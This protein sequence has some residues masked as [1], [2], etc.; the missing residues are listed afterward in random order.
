M[1]GT[2]S[3]V[4]G[5]ELQDGEHPSHKE[6]TTDVK[7]I[8]PKFHSM[9]SVAKTT[10]RRLG[11][12]DIIVSAMGLGVASF[13][14]IYG[15]APS[16]PAEIVRTS[17][18]NGINVID[19]GYWYGQRRSEATLGKAL[20]NIPRHVYYLCIRVGRF[21]LD[22]A[23]PFDYRADKILT[24]LTKSLSLLNQ[25][26]ADICFLQVADTEWENNLNTILEETLPALRIAQNSNKIKY[27]GLAGYS[28]SKMRKIID[29]SSIKIN[30]CLNYCRA[31]LMD[32]SLAESIKYFNEKKIGVLNGGCFSMGMLT[33]QGPPLWHPANYNTR[34]ITKEAVN[35]CKSK[36]IRIEKLSLSYSLR[37]PGITCCLVSIENLSQLVINLTT[38][39]NNG[40]LQN[41]ELRVLDRIKR[42]Y[43]DKIEN[44]EWDII[45]LK[46]YWRHLETLGLPFMSSNRISSME[47]LSSN[48][49]ASI[50]SAC[51]KCDP[52][53]YQK[54][55]RKY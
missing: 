46:G 47:S 25:K 9:D 28:L 3:H 53:K 23:R 37:F 52:Y 18:V 24:S 26:Y 19:T 40:T 21:E 41:K 31:T 12:T 27:I 33:E 17:L 51:S 44:K 49:T 42:R 1:Q 36:D 6:T 38:L 32:N 48:Y 55:P 16:D 43:L 15:P 5:V 20:K 50:A 30:V 35:Y 22:Y 34:E 14:E 8:D 45:N 29:K 13:G 10:Y 54:Y 11:D 39:W 2:L 7:T 4:R